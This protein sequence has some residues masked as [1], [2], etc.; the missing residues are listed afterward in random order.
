MAEKQK[1]RFSDAELSLIKNTFAENDALLESIRKVFLQMEITKS[2]TEI[3][4]VFKG[5]NELISLMSKLF[6][7]KLDPKAPRHQLIDL[8]MSI[9]MKD[10]DVRDL[11]PVFE[12]RQL[13]IDLLEQQL[14]SLEGIAS[15]LKVKEKIQLSK[16]TNIKDKSASEVYTNI[17]ARNTLIT[18]IEAQLTQ[19]DVLAGQRAETV[20][21]T[22]QKLAKNSSK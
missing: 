2:D 12:A 7:P 3:L 19:L 21:Q 6:N 13:L 17:V 20:E 14:K 8:W 22:L 16:L 18:H 4:K 15:G 9:D 10:K 1:M 11:M 5:K